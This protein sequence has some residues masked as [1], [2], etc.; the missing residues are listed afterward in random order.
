MLSHFSQGA[1]ASVVIPCI[2][3]CFL[4]SIAKLEAIENV[5]IRKFFKSEY[6]TGR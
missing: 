2:L 4:A 3:V 5:Q 1:F 6:G